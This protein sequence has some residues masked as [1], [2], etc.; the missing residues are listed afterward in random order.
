MAADGLSDEMIEELREAF[1]LFDR[2]QDGT[3]NSRSEISADFYGYPATHFLQ[4]YSISGI[5]TQP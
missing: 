3:I 2:Q 4:I 1:N 5:C